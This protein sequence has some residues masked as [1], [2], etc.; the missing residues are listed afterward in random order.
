[1]N[2]DIHLAAVQPWDSGAPHINGP[3]RVGASARKPFSHA[4]PVVGERPLVY[5]ADGLPE[6]LSCDPATGLITGEAAR[7]GESRVLLRAENRHGKAEKT[8]DLVFGGTLALTPP[9][10][11]NSWNAWRRW[12]DEPKVRAAADGLVRTGLAVRGYTQVNIDSCWQGVRGGPFN[13][14]QPNRKFPDMKALGDYIHGKGLKFGIYSTPWVCPW[15]AEGADTMKEW[16]GPPLIGCSAGEPDPDYARPSYPGKYVG[17]TKYEANDVAQWVAWGVDY[18]KYDWM[19][20]DARS[21][22]RMGRLLKEA[23]RDIVLSIC[24]EARLKDAEA[25]KAWAHMWR[26]IPDTADNW[27]L[28]RQM[29][30][31]IEDFQGE[32]WRPHIG[33]GA[34]RDLDMFALG[35]QFLSPESTCPNK[36]T[37]AEQVTHMTAWA[38]YPSPLIL[39]CNLDALSEFELRLFG[40][41]EVIAMNQDRLGKLAVRLREERRAG[42]AGEPSRDRRI[43]ARPLSEGRYAVALFNV[44]DADDDLTLEFQ[45]LGIRKR[46]RVRDIWARSDLGSLAERL[47]LPVPAHGARLVL[48][49]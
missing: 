15:G 27:P 34:W 13:A 45:D 46:V 7:E 39:S 16:G 38:I 28:L 29:A 22:E 47:T 1:M 17:L 31:Y 12:V 9:M 26:G 21:L 37:E 20:T 6:G 42:L 10:G 44:A 3:D 48:I 18:L 40:N 49:G 30:F 24:T 2:M 23:A 41:E 33:P 19:P 36:L 4:I 25:F 43:W 11:W 14:I 8:L 32:D 35:P 5:R